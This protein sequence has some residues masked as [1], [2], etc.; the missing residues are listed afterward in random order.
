M[1]EAIEM[2]QAAAKMAI[3]EE[4][5][6]FLNGL[7]FYSWGHADIVRMALITAAHRP[8]LS[9]RCRCGTSACEPGSAAVGTMDRDHRLRE[10]VRRGLASGE[11]FLIDK[12]WAG[13]GS[14]GRCAVCGMTIAFQNVEY[15]VEGARGVAMAHLT[16]YLVWRQ[17]SEAW[18]LR[19]EK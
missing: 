8:F 17:E 7:E 10:R 5:R 18:R 12:S 4:V 14:G 6:A 2:D 16:C 1:N 15:K 19:A 9:E 11:L 13:R 3:F